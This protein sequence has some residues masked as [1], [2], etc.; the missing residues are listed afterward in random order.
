MSAGPLYYVVRALVAD[1]HAGLCT[2][3]THRRSRAPAARPAP[4][5]SPRCTARTSTR[6]SRRASRAAG[7]ASWART[8]CG[9]TALVGW[10]LLVARRVPR[11]PGHA[12]TERRCGAAS[13][14]SRPASRWCCSPRASASRARWCSRCS[15]ARCTSRLRAGVPI[16]PV[17]IGGSERVM[18]KG[19][20]LHL[21]AQGPRHRRRADRVPATADSGRVPRSAIRRHSAELHATP[22]GAVRRRPASVSVSSCRA[23][24]RRDR[25]ARPSDAA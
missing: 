25:G 23:R 6:R 24:V 7:C 3:M 1:V 11:H 2:R 21:P 17:G 12:P 18:P 8:R 20:K 22:A 5:C 13:P 19:A 4:T 15:T 16:V 10:L 9:R 14:W